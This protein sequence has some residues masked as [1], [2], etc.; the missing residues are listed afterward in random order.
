M[1]VF[2]AV[3]TQSKPA[4]VGINSVVE[5]GGL[6]G[7][8][9]HPQANQVTYFGL[10][11]LQHCGQTSAGIVTSQG[12]DFKGHLGRGLIHYVF[13][14][15]DSLASLTGTNAIGQVRSATSDDLADDSNIQPLLFHFNDRSIAIA[16][17]GN[18]TEGVSLRRQLEED[19]AVFSSNSAA[20]ILIHL[21]RRCKEQDFRLALEGGLQRLKGGFNFTLLTNDGLYGAV[22]RHAF[23]PL[24][25]GQFDNG[26]Y[27]LASETC[28]L[29]SIGAT[30]V[31]EL[32]PGQYV[33]I[34]DDGYEIFQY[35]KDC[36]VAI[37]PMEFIYFS[38]PDS[39]IAGVNVHK[40]RKET[41]R[42]LAQDHPAP[43]A[44]IVIGVPNSSLSSASGYAEGHN[45]PYE[46]G[47]VKHQ[48]IGRTFIQPTQELR[49]AGVKAKLSV[50]ESLI[51]DKSI[52]LVDDSIVRGTTI[53]HI[54]RIL[55]DAGA[56][57]IHLR[58]SSPAIRFPNYYGINTM[59]TSELVAANHT[60]Q[61][62]QEMIG[63]DS[64]AFLSVEGLI[65]S[66]NLPFDTE[67]KGL[68][69][70]AYTGQYLDDIGDFKDEFDSTLTSL[71]QAILEGASTDE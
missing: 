14:T 30:F 48:Y 71:Q 44:D 46:I 11:A 22:D 50:V 43:G 47:L 56:K 40:A 36:Q 52:V 64:L 45:L 17:T 49:E 35:E 2:S 39:D 42:R 70:D 69:L 65:E 12:D 60:I 29:H 63:A 6:F 24:V 13:E 18:F 7:V 58:I 23:R 34:N 67:N 27:V 31:Q 9:H 53:R 59:H 57:E 25:I 3:S 19:G 32:A 38:R 4:R 62:L 33:V 26:A 1:D 68:S 51:K 37:E 20:E 54:I 8:W 15:V 16:H 5:S 21:I 61:E 66:I 28:A 41:G 55:K 10:H